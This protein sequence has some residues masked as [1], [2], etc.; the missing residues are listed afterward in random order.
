MATGKMKMGGGTM[1]KKPPPILINEHVAACGKQ[2]QELKKVGARLGAI[3]NPENTHPFI[4]PGGIRYVEQWRSYDG[5]PHLMAVLEIPSDVYTINWWMDMPGGEDQIL[6]PVR[7]ALPNVIIPFLLA[8]CSNGLTY[9]GTMCYFS[10]TPLR[11]LDTMLYPAI[12][13]NCQ[14]HYTG[15]GKNYMSQLC[16]SFANIYAVRS[17]LKT[18]ADWTGAIRS[19]FFGSNWN[20]DED[21]RFNYDNNQI[22]E[23]YPIHNWVKNTARDPSFITKIKWPET[24]ARTLKHILGKAY[25]A[26]HLA[27]VNNDHQFSLVDMQKPVFEYARS[28]PK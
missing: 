1:T 11:S 27:Y 5:G 14:M 21:V 4:L 23:I 28:H 22:D 2:V 10:N 3:P 8:P 6:T 12:L 17:K 13:P 15:Y 26:S 19:D 9:G 16:M 18:L 20:L 24:Y 25:E 7:I